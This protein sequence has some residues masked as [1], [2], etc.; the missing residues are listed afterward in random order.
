[1]CR[2]FHRRRARLEIRSRWPLKHAGRKREVLLKKRG[3]GH[4]VTGAKAMIGKENEVR[5]TALSQPSN[6]LRDEESSQEK[7]GELLERNG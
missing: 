5:F 4:L 6:V 3:N 1:M 2:T 7:K